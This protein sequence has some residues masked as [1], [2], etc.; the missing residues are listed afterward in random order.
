MSR[1]LTYADVAAHTARHDLYVI[2]H[3]KVLDL[4]KF[5]DEHPGGEE[6]LVDQGG[7]DATDAFEDVGHSADAR[8]IL[9]TLAIG[10]LD[11]RVGSQ[12]SSAL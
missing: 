5:I 10:T 6:V 11:R 9:D 1:T 12:D 4:S 7:K 8:R 2:I 3:S